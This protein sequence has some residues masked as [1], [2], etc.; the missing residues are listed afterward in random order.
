VLN[1][2]TYLLFA[3]PEAEV[4]GPEI[5]FGSVIRLEDFLQVPSG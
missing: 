4:S 2:V 3:L 5:S 1:G